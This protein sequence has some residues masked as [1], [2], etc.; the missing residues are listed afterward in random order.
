MALLRTAWVLWLVWLSVALPDASG[1]SR[2]VEAMFA[3]PGGRTLIPEFGDSYGVVFRDLNHDGLPDLYVVRFRNLNRLFV[4]PG[5]GR[6]FV[7]RTIATGLGGNLMPRK[8][9]NLE[10]GG[11]AV[12]F[13]DDGHVDVLILGWGVSTRLF[14]QVKHF[15]FQDVTETMGFTLPLDGNM[16]IWGDVDRDGDLDLFITD[17]HHPNHLLINEKGRFFRDRASEYGVDSPAVS[18][19]A[20]FADVDQDGDLDLYVCNWF[21]PD[22]L[23]EN[24]GGYE[25]QRVE[26]PLFH[27]TRPVNSN[28]VSFADVDNDGDLDFLVADRDGRSRLYLNR[29]TPGDTVWS[30][31]EAPLPFQV[32]NAYPAYGSV[33]A[34]LNNDGWQ[35]IYFTNI[36]PNQFFLNRGGRI[37]ELAFQERLSR[38]SHSQNYST[39]VAVADVDQ[40][41]DLDLFVANKDTHSV[42]LLNPLNTRHSIRFALEGVGSNRDAIGAKIWLY[43][44]DPEGQA[45][46]LVGYREIFGGQGYLSFSEPVA[47][48]G[49]APESRYIARIVFPSGT[50]IWKTSLEAGHRYRVEEKTGLPKFAFRF[51]HNFQRLMLEPNFWISLGLSLMILIM[52]VVFLSLTGSRY[53]WRNMS[54]NGF[55]LL[56]LVLLYGVFWFYRDAPV[57]KILL[58]QLGILV[59]LLGSTIAVL[60][61]I[62]QIEKRRFGYR[63]LL[64]TFS[65]DLI[66]IKTNSELFTQL[67]ATIHR[68]LDSTLCLVME[69]QGEVLREVVRSGKTLPQ[70]SEIRL[71]HEEQRLLTGGKILACTEV[72]KQLPYFAGIPC[73]YLIPIG[74]RDTLYAVLVLVVGEGRRELSAE[75]RSLLQIVANQA[76]IAIE[77]N[78]FIEETKQLIQK[79]TEAEVR[80]KYVQQ[81]ERKNQELARLYQ[82][83][84]DA[85]AQ[86]I[87]SEKMSSL[88]QLV[89]G[90]AHELNNPLS[91]VYANLKALQ[92][93]VEALSQV[94]HTV[95]AHLERPD[96]RQ[97]LQQTIQRLQQS[98]D[99]NFILKDTSTL[100]RESLEGSR[101]VKEVV[102]NLRNFSRLDEA[103]CKAVDLHEGLESTLVLLR[104]ELRDRIQ[105]HKQ[106]GKLP[107][108]T[109][110]P[111]QINQVFM[112][113]LLNAIQAIEGKGNIWIRTSVQAG[114]VSVEIR[115]DGKGIP[116]EVLP[117]I[118]DPFFTTKPVGE[119]TGLGLSICY[120]IVQD[121]GGT[122]EVES[123]PGGGSIFRIYLPL[124][125]SRNKE[126]DE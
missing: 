124:S 39:G 40:D 22:A 23:Y 56:I 47:H 91:F 27:L 108:V 61:K 126:S 58:I 75:D 44:Q 57:Q 110:Q 86:L 37:L 96:L 45:A 51:I 9:E 55:I 122:I 33:I 41:G 119:G 65:Q 18:Q 36:G 82:E 115:D 94:L 62:H 78:R 80:E 104:N 123:E 42:L 43:V 52:I 97:R 114:T 120:R 117:H 20:A 121:H 66:F 15:R 29:M 116:K 6:P 125:R 54:F 25:F 35:D 2:W 14:R 98:H 69:K 81:L 28:S 74:R 101:R 32:R 19:G 8:K 100:I 1:E 73:D 109:C 106:Y 64:Q 60:E 85:Q 31:Q 77:N 112:N 71:T 21:A 7:D 16:G 107:L 4:N 87:Q 105:V 84:K 103:E 118:F 63:K 79:I 53:R 68:A 30:F 46:Q 11:S 34:D 99:L 26:L 95:L 48:F 93:Y 5:G 90:V 10:L 70:T 49:V 38:S 83:L 76:A 67:A 17:E 24:R 50:E 89:A 102:Q 111:G 92:E 3:R 12:D 13:D 72:R 59:V 88:G 113:I